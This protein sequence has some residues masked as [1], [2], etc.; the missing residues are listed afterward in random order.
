M[1]HNEDNTVSYDS[2]AWWLSSRIHMLNVFR[3]HERSFVPTTAVRTHRKVVYFPDYLWQNCFLPE[4]V[5]HIT[6]MT[7]RKQRII[8]HSK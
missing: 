6:I 2:V 1:G 3:A 8:V 7:I 5:L 4:Q